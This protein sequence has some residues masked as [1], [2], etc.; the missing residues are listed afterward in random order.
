MDSLKVAAFF[1]AV[2][3]LGAIFAFVIVA[4]CTDNNGEDDPPDEPEPTK[5]T[6]KWADYMGR[7]AVKAD[8]RSDAYLVCL[9][10]L[11]LK[12]NGT[13]VMTE[14]D[15]ITLYYGSSGSDLFYRITVDM[16][17]ATDFEEG[18]VA[19]SL[20]FTKGGGDVANWTAN[21]DTVLPLAKNY[22]LKPDEY[23]DRFSVQPANTIAKDL[24]TT[25]PIACVRTQHQTLYFDATNGIYLDR[26][27]AIY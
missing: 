18:E 26:F 6:A 22:F 17:G 3:L 23:A 7:K 11:N 14:A 5:G 12:I 25:H 2:F 16:N 13:G 20:V 9:S 24:N 27:S 1:G 8:W 21:S 4:G 10:W 15:T 19:K